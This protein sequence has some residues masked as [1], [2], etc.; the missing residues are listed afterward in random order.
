MKVGVKT[1]NELSSLHEERNIMIKKRLFFPLS[2]LLLLLLH[3]LLFLLVFPRLNQILAL[4]D[5]NWLPLSIGHIIDG[6]DE[7][8]LENRCQQIGNEGGGEDA[9]KNS[10]KMV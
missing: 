9:T 5:E 1:W 8:N 6:E 2:I 4:K 10:W 7:L 3:H